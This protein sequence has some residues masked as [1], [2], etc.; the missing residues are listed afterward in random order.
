MPNPSELA[1]LDEGRRSAAEA[2]ARAA[3]RVAGRGDSAFGPGPLA[4]FLERQAALS[5]TI[6]VLRAFVDGVL[7]GARDAERAREAERP[8]DSSPPP[9]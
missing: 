7:D 5:S 8:D 9:A 4:A 3:G 2:A 1:R 6:L